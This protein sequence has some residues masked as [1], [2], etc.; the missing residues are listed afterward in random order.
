M[1]ALAAIDFFNLN[2]TAF[3]AAHGIDGVYAKPAI[4][5][6]PRHYLLGHTDLRSQK[7]ACLTPF[8]AAALRH[9]S[10]RTL[11]SSAGVNAQ[12]S[13]RRIENRGAKKLGFGEWP[14][15]PA[16]RRPNQSKKQWHCTQDAVCR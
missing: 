3:S 12:L 14:L 2:D 4:A 8:V 11:Q 6:E 10:D 5:N 16:M 1:E 13:T 9:S 7:G 15:I